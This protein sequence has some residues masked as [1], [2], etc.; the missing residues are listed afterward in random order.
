MAMIDFSCGTQSLWL[1]YSNGNNKDYISTNKF[2]Y[3]ITFDFL[4]ENTTT[5]SA[6]LFQNN[7][8]VDENLNDRSFENKKAWK[9]K[10]IGKEF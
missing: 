3:S 6:S 5:I 9:H 2:V 8:D 7:K 4:I 1:L 10:Q